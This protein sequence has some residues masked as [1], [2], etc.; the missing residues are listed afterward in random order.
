[1]PRRDRRLA[2]LPDVGRD[3]GYA[4]RTLRRSPAFAVTALLSLALGMAATA[5][6]FSLVDQ[7]LLRKLRGVHEPQRLVLLNWN[8]RDLATDY[9]RPPLLSYPICRELQEQRQVFEGVF[10]RHPAPVYLST[11]KQHDLVAAEI[12]SGSYFSVLGVRPAFGRLI[13]PSDDLQPGAH[14]VVVLCTTIGARS[15]DRL[16]R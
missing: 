2:W 10:C 11:G 3:I 14:P 1:M 12:V 4:L 13:D 6:I 8:G 9:G 16:R 5:G 15:S 7:V